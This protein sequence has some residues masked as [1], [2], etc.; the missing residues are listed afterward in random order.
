VDHFSLS[1][2]LPVT[3][4]ILIAIGIAVRVIMRR[5]ATGVALA[6]ILF[7]VALPFGGAAIYLIIGERRLSP[8]RARR[9]LMQHD[10]FRALCD[11]MIADG[12]TAVDWS[13]HP[14]AAEGISR[15]GLHTTGSPALRGSKVE[16]LSDAAEIFRR[17]AADIDAA[18]NSLLMEFYIWNAGGGADDI[19]E[20]VIRA[21][22]RGVACRLLIDA[23]GAGSWW[24]GDQPE[25]L[26]DAGVEL[27]PAL[28]VGLLRTLVGRTDLR[29]HRK[30]VAIDG[31]VAW[32]GSMN[33]VDPRYFKQ[34]AGVGQ[35]IDAMMRIEGAAVTPLAAIAIG[36]WS[37]ETDDDPNDFLPPRAT[38][39]AGSGTGRGNADIQVI[40]SGPGEQ[41]NAM[42]QM[43][44]AAVNAAERRLTIT[45]PYLVPDDSL[46]WALRGAAGRGVDVRIVLPE[47]VDSILTRHAS[48]SYYQDLLD[49]GIGLHLYPDGLL[50]TKS[51]TV[52]G[53]LAMF[54]TVN[55]D[56]RS[57]WLNYEVALFIYDPG[58][59]VEL[60]RLQ[61][62]YL[63]R[64]KRLD[65][66]AWGARPAP[67][68]FI[69]SALR[70][71]GPL[72]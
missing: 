18:E 32:T 37:V 53:K 14:R 70:I 2:N 55:F 21:A 48:R 56:M 11:Q 33:L 67:R 51:L 46:L 52:D 35:W 71:V 23:L 25:R 6:W 36:D 15:L 43:L 45:T 13:R 12:H 72:L 26:K 49:A 69:E 9:Q 4:H 57:L 61:Q 41:G 28:P 65:A 60:E 40:P 62:S 20:A 29:L 64:C 39:Y 66:A 17:L 59:T 54:G 68:R 5:P 24:R 7:V 19:L 58:V 1:I 38:N 8:R 47:T 31:R 44:L 42:L 63:D 30:I 27:R 10:D 50:H 34:D 22:R 16:L 3:L